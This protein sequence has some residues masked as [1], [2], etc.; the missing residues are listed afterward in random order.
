MDM[1]MIQK[2]LEVLKLVNGPDSF[3]LLGTVFNEKPEIAMLKTMAMLLQGIRNLKESVSVTL[4]ED[5]DL[6][7]EILG[8]QSES[9]EICMKHIPAGNTLEDLY[10]MD[11]TLEMEPIKDDQIDFS[12]GMAGGRDGMTSSLSV[13]PLIIDN[14]ILNETLQEAVSAWL[15]FDAHTYKSIFEKEYSLSSSYRHRWGGVSTSEITELKENKLKPAPRI[16]GRTFEKG[17]RK[18]KFYGPKKFGGR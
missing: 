8:L 15:S 9:E 18:S 14:P 1:E 13:Q 3:E 5:S 12:I 7:A 16:Q 2:Y 10:I 17:K 4:G 6:Y 11:H